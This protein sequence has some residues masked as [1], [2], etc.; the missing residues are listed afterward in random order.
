M[1]DR[2]TAEEFAPEA[3]AAHAARRTWSFDY[4]SDAD[5]AEI[6]AIAKRIGREHG[7]RI[8]VRKGT[9]SV[10]D[11]VLISTWQSENPALRIELCEALIAAGFEDTHAPYG[12]DMSLKG[13]HVY[14]AH[15]W[16]H[17]EVSLMVARVRA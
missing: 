16:E 14:L 2:I 12:F 4:P 9:G 1:N 6:R 17:S 8:S 11:A 13:H 10:K 5:R 3:A 7:H 15:V